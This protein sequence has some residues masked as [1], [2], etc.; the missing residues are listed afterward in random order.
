MKQ[1]FSLWKICVHFKMFGQ[2][3]ESFLC[4][5]TTL[6]WC[7][8]KCIFWIHRNSLR[9]FSF[10]IKTFL[11]FWDHWAR[12]FWPFVTQISIR[13]STKFYVCKE[14][15]WGKIMEQ[16]YAFHQYPSLD[17]TYLAIFRFFSVGVFK[18]QFNFSS[19]PVIF[20]PWVKNFRPCAET[21]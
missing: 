2:G 13:L 14:T 11:T 6:R 17:N 7:C 18:T 8:Q 3:E 20:G 15:F 10:L 12:N 19:L 1:K 9:K 4:L 21:I 16:F 5:S